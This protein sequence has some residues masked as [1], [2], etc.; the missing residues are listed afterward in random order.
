MLT[1]LKATR[2]AEFLGIDEILSKY[3]KDIF[4]ETDLYVT[5]EPCVM[6]A[7]ALR[8]LEIRKV[9][10][11]AANDRFGGCGSVL[12]LHNHAKLP[13]PAYNVYPGFYRDE[14]IVML[15]KFYVQENT[16]APVHR[17]KKTRELKLEVE[18]NFDYS[19]FVGSEEEFINV[20]GKE[21][22]SEYRKLSS[23]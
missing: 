8:Q 3:D 10:F 15:R 11:G 13:E 21:R 9:Y 4:K 2:H 6:C 7:S 17:G 19:K 14:A 18:D 12:S 20:Y 1:S 16:K 5:V 23:K 22:L